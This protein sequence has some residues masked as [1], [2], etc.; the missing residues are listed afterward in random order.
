LDAGRGEVFAQPFDL[1]GSRAR[2]SAD[3][4][5]LPREEAARAIAGTRFVALPEDLLGTGGE[6]LAA[7]PAEALARASARDPRPAAA[8][9]L[10][11]IYARASAAEEKIGAS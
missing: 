8:S 10:Q 1:E 6:D 3:L 2:A 5:R 7:M 4:S 9:P 11:P